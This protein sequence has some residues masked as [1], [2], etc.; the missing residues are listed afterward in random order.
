MSEDSDI[1]FEESDLGV[2]C[3]GRKL[4]PPAS[5]WLCPD[6]VLPFEWVTMPTLTRPCRRKSPPKNWTEVDGDCFA[7]WRE[8]GFR[9][10]AYQ[11]HEECMIKDSGTLRPCLA[12]E[13]ELLQGLEQDYTA[14]A[15]S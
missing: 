9:Y 14:G 10:P 3:H 12:D 1:T 7:R 13:R 5:T 6:A 2:H 15:C 4:W 11:Y 8:D